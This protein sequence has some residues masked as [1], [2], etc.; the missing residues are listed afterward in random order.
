MKIV[1]INTYKNTVMFAILLMSVMQKL[2]LLSACKGQIKLLG[3]PIKYKRI[4]RDYYPLVKDAVEVWGILKDNFLLSLKG[5][6]L[7]FC[8]H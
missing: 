3:R 8:S 1:F 4:V 5:G 7:C 6:F 2:E